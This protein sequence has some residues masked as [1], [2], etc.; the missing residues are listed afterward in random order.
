MTSGSLLAALP[1]AAI[2]LALSVLALD[3]FQ[4]DYADALCRIEHVREQALADIERD[5]PLRADLAAAAAACANLPPLIDVTSLL[6][7]PAP[8][9]TP[10]LEAPTP[11]ATQATG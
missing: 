8:T 1:F 7:T 2:V 4:N 11:T 3:A 9:L 5:E 6:P 10:T